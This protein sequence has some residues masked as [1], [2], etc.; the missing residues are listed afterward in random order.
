MNCFLNEVDV[1][2]CSEDLVGQSCD[3]WDCVLL[4]DVFYDCYIAQQLSSW[5]Q[6]L[7]SKGKIVLVGDPGRSAFKLVNKCRLMDVAKYSLTQ[8]LC[9]ENY[10]F[11]DVTV[12]R[13]K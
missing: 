1:D 9:E 6:D 5:L 11:T 8:D 10:G 3:G 4:G 12:W 2:V 7:S 13:L